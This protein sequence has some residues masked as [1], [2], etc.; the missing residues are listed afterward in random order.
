MLKEESNRKTTFCLRGGIEEEEN[1]GI[2]TY[3]TDYCAC[4]NFIYIF[5]YGGNVLQES[6]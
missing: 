4:Y 5:P 3:I 6:N 2:D 1:N